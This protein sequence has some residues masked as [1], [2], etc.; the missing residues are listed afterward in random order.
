TKV[1]IAK[2]NMLKDRHCERVIFPNEKFLFTA[3]E[4]CELEIY[5]QTD[6]GIIKDVIPCSELKL[7]ESLT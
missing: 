7:V 4:N 1:V 2:I 6:G 3:D 5:Q